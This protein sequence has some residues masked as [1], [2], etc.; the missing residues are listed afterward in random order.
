[1]S[2]MMLTANQQIRHQ[3]NI[4]SF[5]LMEITWPQVVGVI[6]SASGEPVICNRFLIYM[7]THV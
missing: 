4:F 7:K 1:M 5:H 2:M 3:W 6:V